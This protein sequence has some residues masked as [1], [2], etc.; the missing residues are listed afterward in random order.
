GPGVIAHLGGADFVNDLA[1]PGDAA[2]RC[3]AGGKGH[4]ASGGGDD[5]LESLL[6]VFRLIDFVVAPFEVEAQHGNAPLIDD[7]GV[8]IAVAVLVGDHFA[9]AGEVDAGAVDLAD[10][11]LQVLA[12]AAAEER[13]RSAEDA[14]AGHAASAADL[15]MIAARERH[16]AGLLLLVQ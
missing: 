12:V 13:V 14:G 10:I 9:A 7:V 2:A 3:V 6:H 15:D 4:L 5:L 1:R 8:E 11:A 16:L